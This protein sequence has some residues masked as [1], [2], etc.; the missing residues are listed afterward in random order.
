MTEYPSGDYIV[1]SPASVL[2]LSYSNYYQDFSDIQT[3]RQY[4]LTFQVA[5]IVENAKDDYSGYAR[6]Y[7]T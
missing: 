1:S 7:L 6:S 2:D 3:E 5:K 4:F